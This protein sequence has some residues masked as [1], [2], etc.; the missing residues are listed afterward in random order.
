MKWPGLA[1][2]VVSVL[3]V[4]KG[5]F[6][7]VK[8][9]DGDPVD[10][11]TA[12]LFHRGG[13]DDPARLKANAGKSFHRYV[14]NFRDYPLRREDVGGQWAIADKEQR[15]E[16]LRSGI[17]PLD[18]PEP[19]AA[20][21]PRLQRIVQERVQPLRLKDNRA[22][23]RRN[24]WKY[25]EKRVDLYVS[26][27][28]LDRV[29]AVN[30]GA[31]PQ[32]GI[33]FLPARMVFAN[34][35]VVFPCRTYAAFCALQSRPH[36]VWARFFGSS[37]KDDLR[38]TP[39]DC[40]ET[41]PFPDEWN[42]RP[43][44]ERVGGDYYNYRADLM[45]RHDE[46]L[47]KTYNRFHDPDETDPDIIRLRQLHAAM[48]RTVLDAYGW[49]DIPTDCEFLPAYVMEEHEQEAESRIYRY[50][51]PDVVR[52]KVFDRLWKLNTKRADEEVRAGLAANS[53]P[54]SKRR[55]HKQSRE[56]PRR[57]HDHSQSTLWEHGDD[58]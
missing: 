32:F 51:W 33:G 47:T 4:H 39:S 15:R 3:Q 12:F 25:A 43:D 1:A 45:I 38:Y 49:S 17:V 11:I 28:G 52:D 36:E 41:F 53:A 22:A 23:Y 14:I 35:L 19:V 55:S 29:L 24:W 26:A 20:D 7:G 54:P 16:W 40:F 13:H 5:A 42:S 44:L 50:R 48:D 9:L 18:Y 8:R 34:T 58:G 27:A 10:M 30:C 57:A 56:R 37:I 46:G 31:T 21:W 2:V 6:P